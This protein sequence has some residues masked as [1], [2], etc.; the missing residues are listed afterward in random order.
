M[1]FPLDLHEPGTQWKHSLSV[2][3]FAV[4]V[5]FSVFHQY[6]RKSDLSNMFEIALNMSLIKSI[7]VLVHKSDIF[8]DQPKASC[9]GLHINSIT[10]L[11]VRFG[12]C[13]TLFAIIQLNLNILQK[14]CFFYYGVS[15]RMHYTNKN[16]AAMIDNT[17]ILKR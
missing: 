5:D 11:N 8:I 13:G 2:K 7:I 14:R 4:V 15:S 12:S 10:Y 16:F 3:K 9:N 17:N 1:Y 6:L